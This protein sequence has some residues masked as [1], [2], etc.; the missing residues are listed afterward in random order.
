MQTTLIQGPTL[1]TVAATS[2]GDTLETLLA[3][4]GEP[5]DEGLSKLILIPAETGIYWSRTSASASSPAIA[6]N[7]ITLDIRHTEAALLKFYAS[8]KGMTILQFGPKA[9]QG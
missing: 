9:P 5:L 7:V 2:G 8:N 3:V 4:K 6:A 1:V